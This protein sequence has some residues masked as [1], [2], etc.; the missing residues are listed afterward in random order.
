[1]L[2]L[3]ILNVRLRACPADWQ[4]MTPTAQ[5][6]HC[7]S[8]D[9]EVIDF[10]SGTQ[11]DLNAARAAASDGHLCGRFRAEQLAPSQ[12]APLPRRVALRPRLRRFLVALVLVCGLGLTSGEAWAQVRKVASAASKPNQGK[13]LS[14]KTLP[15]AKASQKAPAVSTVTI[16]SGDVQGLVAMDTLTRIE[17]E[18]RVYS[19]VE[20][21]PE[22]PGGR[23][24]I[25]SFVQKNLQ[26]PPNTGMLDAEGR[27]FV[28][29]IVGADGKLRD[30]KVL[31]GLHPLLDA[32]ALRV[33]R[34]MEGKFVVGRQNGRAVNV[35]YTIPLT[36]Q[37]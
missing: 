11:A 21:M 12:P 36:F 17:V 37:R 25:Q 15:T 26:W 27:V 2:S 29:F 4:Q 14:K 20:Q 30:F 16:V 22:F 24:G 32:E 8:C 1:M 6:R 19:Y 31:K 10:T 18:P 33:A 23:E 28:N 5:G 34:L 35:Y 3:P 9:R 13:T 7:H